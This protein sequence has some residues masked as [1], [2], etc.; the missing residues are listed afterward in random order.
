MFVID[1]INFNMEILLDGFFIRSSTSQGSADVAS[2]SGM[3]LYICLGGTYGIPHLD[4]FPRVR[5]GLINL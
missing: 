5:D 2:P 3:A 1:Y 4:T